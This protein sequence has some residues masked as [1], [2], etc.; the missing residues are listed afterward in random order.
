[1]RVYKNFEEVLEEFERNKKQYKEGHPL[2]KF[3]P[4]QDY[5]DYFKPTITLINKLLDN[6][7]KDEKNKF[8]KLFLQ[9]KESIIVTV[10]GTTHLNLTQ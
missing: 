4:P 3:L 7:T 6:C 9:K 10:R 2:N 1:M 8:I 5:P